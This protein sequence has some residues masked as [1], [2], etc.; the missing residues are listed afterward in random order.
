MDY[1]CS[2]LAGNQGVKS[3]SSRGTILFPIPYNSSVLGIANSTNANLSEPRGFGIYNV[4]LTGFSYTQRAQNADGAID[5][6]DPNFV[7]SFGI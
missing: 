3:N 4:T 2:Q 6:S 1:L 5:I 7:I